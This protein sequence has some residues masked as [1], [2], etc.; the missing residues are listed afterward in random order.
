MSMLAVVSMTWCW[1]QEY[2]TAS[3]V[4]FLT[5]GPNGWRSLRGAR[6]SASF[7]TMLVGVNVVP[8]PA[9]RPRLLITSVCAAASL[10]G[11]ST[12]EPGAPR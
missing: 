8:G 6:P 2:G 11:M 12:T 4:K 7:S 5:P 10:A 1:Y 3:E 9:F